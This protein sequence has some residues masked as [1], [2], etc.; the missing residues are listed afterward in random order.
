MRENDR[1]QILAGGMQSYMI[2]LD[3]EKLINIAK[4]YNIELG[5]YMPFVQMYENEM[6]KKQNRKMESSK[7]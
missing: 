2:G 4:V 6:I 3:K 7:S 5:R 1:H